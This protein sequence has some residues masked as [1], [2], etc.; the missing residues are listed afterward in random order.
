M[1][2]HSVGGDRVL[3]LG[4]GGRGLQFFGNIVSLLR[5]LLF[6]R[7]FGLRCVGDDV[8]GSGGQVGVEC[9]LGERLIFLF[10]LLFLLLLICARVCVAIGRACG[11]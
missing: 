6:V 7:L 4:C 2:I 11:G 10:R 8:D 5:L 3:H 9:H 1:A